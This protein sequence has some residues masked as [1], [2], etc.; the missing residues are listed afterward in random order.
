MIYEE[1][2]LSLL[3]GKRLVAIEYKLQ[4]KHSLLLIHFEQQEQEEAT[5]CLSR[6][7]FYSY[8]NRINDSESILYGL[9]ECIKP[10]NK[11]LGLNITQ[12]NAANKLIGSKLTHFV[13][14]SPCFVN[15]END[16]FGLV[17]NFVDPFE[18]EIDPDL[19]FEPK[20]KDFMKKVWY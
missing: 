12:E 8:D 10:N 20:V 3:E 4:E 18:F 17:M 6:E 5:L 13:R 7:I 2:L 1:D 14:L 11:T 15:N 19:P 9:T 16:T